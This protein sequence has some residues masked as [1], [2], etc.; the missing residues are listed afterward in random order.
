MVWCLVVVLVGRCLFVGRLWMT[1]Y[2]VVVADPP[3]PQ[4]LSGKR[5]GGNRVGKG[6]PQFY[7]ASGERLHFGYEKM[8]VAD[9]FGVMDERVFPLCA[10]RHVVFLWMI[11]KFLVDAEREMAARGYKL[12]ARLVWDKGT[13]LAP[14]FTVRYSH[15]YVG[16]F[17]KRP[18]LPIAKQMRGKV[19][20]VFREYRREHSRK[21]DTLYRIVEQLYPD[22][23]RL[24][25]F[26]REKRDGWDQWGNETDHFG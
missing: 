2:G 4:G 22:E 24:D 26:S 17:Y 7:W 15:E 12:H 9:C 13:G 6:G 25:A 11:D 14:A 3:W 23:R 19:P 20:T 18:M 16:W 8:P 21:P 10:A 1:G 5:R